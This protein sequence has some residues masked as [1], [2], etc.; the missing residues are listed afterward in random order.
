MRI[1]S[2]KKYVNILTTQY[3]LEASKLLFVLKLFLLK[4]KIRNLRYNLFIVKV[5]INATNFEEFQLVHNILLCSVYSLF[6]QFLERSRLVRICGRETSNPQLSSRKPSRFL[7]VC[8]L[9]FPYFFWLIFS[10]RLFCFIANYLPNLFS[11]T[12]INYVKSLK[13]FC[14]H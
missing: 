1:S 6:V 4:M 11:V 13:N 14:S 7:R 3:P 10:L 12:E 8:F 2:S 5:I 9:F